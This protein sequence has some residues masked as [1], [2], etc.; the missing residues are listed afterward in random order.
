MAMEP[1]PLGFGDFSITMDASLA[2]L[3]PPP[4]PQDLHSHQSVE[5]VKQ[6]L[7]AA[8][9]ELQ[10]AREEER[11]KEQDMKALAELIRHTAQE[12]D[13]LREQ[14]QLLLA[15]ELEAVM[16]SSSD[17][18]RS[19]LAS[20]SPAA[21]FVPSMV[22]QAAAINEH[23]SAAAPAQL[24]TKMPVALGNSH[25]AQP[26][27][28]GHAAAMVNRRGAVAAQLDLLA[29]KRPLPPRGRL[30]QAVMEAG[31][32]L[33]NLMVAGPLPRWRNPPQAQ[34]L[35]NAMISAPSGSGASM[36]LP[37]STH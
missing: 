1:L 9:A 26:S 11:H 30:V 28:V 33:Q 23:P 34:A 20:S 19:P 16:S 22:P 17:S 13:L 8:T 21:L 7:A 36:G 3:W 32:L 29:A 37:W 10:A 24:A 27:S 4:P 25:S 6:R 18:G 31:P 5:E 35:T 12:R 14:H 15:R 2:S